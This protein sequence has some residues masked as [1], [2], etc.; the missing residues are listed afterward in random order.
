VRLV[1]SFLQNAAV[2]LEPREFAVDKALGRCGFEGRLRVSIG[3]GFGGLKCFHCIA[4]GVAVN[5]DDPYLSG[6]MLGFDENL[7]KII[8]T[9]E[10]IPEFCT[11]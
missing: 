11:H 6:G 9:L 5:V 2:E 1:E 4:R 10:L 7:G 8:L 3:T